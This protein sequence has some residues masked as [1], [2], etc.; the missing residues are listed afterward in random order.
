MIR[1]EKDAHSFVSFFAL[2]YS[3]RPAHPL[4]CLRILHPL[5]LPGPLQYGSNEVIIICACI[6]IQ[7]K[8]VKVPAH[9]QHPLPFKVRL[10]C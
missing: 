8:N 10:I 2:S 7:Y 9:H 3:H 4:H 1:N 5:V 6:E